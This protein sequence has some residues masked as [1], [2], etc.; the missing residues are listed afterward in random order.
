MHRGLDLAGP[1]LDSVKASREEEDE[2]ERRVDDDASGTGHGDPRKHVGD[3]GFMSLGWD[4]DANLRLEG[5]RETLLSVDPS[6]L[7][8]KPDTRQRNWM[9]GG[10]ARETDGCRSHIEKQH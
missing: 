2:R 9:Q 6:M 4:V 8:T 10:R 1:R 5:D 3:G 7:Q